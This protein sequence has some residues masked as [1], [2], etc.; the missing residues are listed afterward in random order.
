MFIPIRTDRAP[1]RRP[2]ATQVIIGINLVIFIVAH[3]GDRSDWFT[4]EA[5]LGAGHFDPQAIRPWQL[6]TY[7]FLH[8][9]NS[10][11]HIGANMVFLWVVGSAVEGRLRASGFVPLYLLGGMVAGIGH[12]MLS[13][14]PVIGASG[15]VAAVTGAYL[16]LFPRSSV[17]VLVIFFVIGLYS[18]PSL[19]FI[20]FYVAL[21]LINALL[22]RGGGVLHQPRTT[23]A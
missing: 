22:D 6:I 1:R 15:S 17:Q 13:G 19:W 4:M 18:I 2:V 7:Q 23:R 21:D 20:G 10:F 5:F 11:W 8:A 16:A 14:N 9:P 3:L 12:L